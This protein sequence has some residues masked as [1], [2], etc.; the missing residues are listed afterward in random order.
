MLSKR[1][2][3]RTALIAMLIVVVAFSFLPTLY[4]R[5]KFAKQYEALKSIV[6]RRSQGT[7]DG[8]EFQAPNGTMLSVWTTEHE[9]VE[10]TGLVEAKNFTPD[11]TRFFVLPPG[12]W[13]RTFDEVLETWDQHD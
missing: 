7:A 8:Y 4:R 13:V 10:E 12:K 6:W 11:P 3:I 1:C 2:S 9:Y 5:V